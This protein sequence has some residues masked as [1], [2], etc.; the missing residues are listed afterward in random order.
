MLMRDLYFPAPAPVP[1]AAADALRPAPTPDPTDE[2]AEA[3][4]AAPLAK[5]PANATCCLS[6]TAAP[7]EI[8]VGPYV[9][10]NDDRSWIG[11]ARGGESVGG[12]VGFVEEAGMGVVPG[13]DCT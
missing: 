13:G 3:L 6:N 2:G 12:G 10:Q 7:V 4:A 8:I 1:A 11:A 5:A 9:C